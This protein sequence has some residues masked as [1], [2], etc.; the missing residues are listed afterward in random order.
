VVM[1]PWQLLSQCSSCTPQ[2]P[3]SVCTY[4]TWQSMEVRCCCPGLH[5]PPGALGRRGPAATRRIR[6]LF[7]WRAHFSSVHRPCSYA[8][9]SAEAPT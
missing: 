3:C 4:T 8:G 9:T 7:A 1:G 2:Q 5:S 6:C